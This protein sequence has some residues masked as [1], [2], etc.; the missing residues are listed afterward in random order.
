MKKIE[1]LADIDVMYDQYGDEFCSQ[2]GGWKFQ[3]TKWVQDMQH[4]GDILAFDEL[5]GSIDIHRLDTH[6][7]TTLLGATKHLREHLTNWPDKF[8]DARSLLVYRNEESMV[9][10][11]DQLRTFE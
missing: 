3:I 7:I 5:F 1:T 11:L 2:I 9:R 8:D 10:Y 4:D 6:I